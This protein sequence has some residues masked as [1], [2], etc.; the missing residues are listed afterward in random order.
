MDFRGD[1]CVAQN[2]RVQKM[3]VIGLKAIVSPLPEIGFS[4]RLDDQGRESRIDPPDGWRIQPLETRME[5]GFLKSFV[6]E[7]VRH[8][9][10]PSSSH[11]PH[12]MEVSF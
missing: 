11:M 3:A 7:T 1:G 9:F 2:F 5:A 10:V 8:T 6:N 12:G 4:L